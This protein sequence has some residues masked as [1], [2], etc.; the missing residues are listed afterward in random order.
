MEDRRRRDESGEWKSIR[1]GWFLG[2][3]ELKGKLLE[4]MGS[5]VGEHHGGE[6]K[7]ENE[8]Q[9]AERLV[10]EELG[11][12]RWTEVNLKERQKD[13]YDRLVNKWLEWNQTML[14]EVDESATGNFTGEQ[15]AD[16][17]G[18]QPTSRKADNPGPPAQ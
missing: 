3:A 15:L 13:V 5:C 9:K 17:I 18:A 2:G 12:H 1:R 16:H 14:P 8:E 6:E 4:Q 7:Q 11:K 10:A